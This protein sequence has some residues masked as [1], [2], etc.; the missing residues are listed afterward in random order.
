MM[1]VK[2]LSKY[3]QYF[4]STTA[5]GAGADEDIL[6][7]QLEY[8]GRVSSIE[9]FGPDVQDYRVETQ[10]YDVDTGNPVPGTRSTEYVLAGNENYNVGEFEDPLFTFGAIKQ[11]NIVTST[12]LSADDYGINVRVDE[13]R[14]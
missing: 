2:E 14:G 10:D 9:I 8:E 7:I 11:I 12:A 13:L 5:N 1:H 3:Q 4:R 6:T